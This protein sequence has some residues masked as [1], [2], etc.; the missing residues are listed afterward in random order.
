MICRKHHN[1]YQQDTELVKERRK[2]GRWGGK[3][4]DE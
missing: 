2:S 3:K 1:L 4:K